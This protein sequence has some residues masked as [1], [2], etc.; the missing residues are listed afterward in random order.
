MT[1]QQTMALRANENDEF[2]F[3][4]MERIYEKGL[5]PFKTQ[6]LYERYVR[7]VCRKKSA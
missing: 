6:D 7:R 3:Y 2:N 1:P 4:A 5:D